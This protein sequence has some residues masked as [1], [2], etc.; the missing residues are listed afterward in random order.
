VS[1]EETALM[2]WKGEDFINHGLFVDDRTDIKTKKA[3]VDEITGGRS[4]DSSI[5]KQY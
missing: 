1:S 5:C 4:L 3:L 2:K